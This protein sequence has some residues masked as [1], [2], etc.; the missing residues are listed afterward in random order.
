MLCDDC[1]K[2]PAC[3]HIT[4]VNNNQK[5]EKHLCEYCAQKT[6]EFTFTS[7]SGLSVQ[8][9]LKGMFNQG[10]AEAPQKTVVCPNCGMSYGDFSHNG[11]IGCSVCYST[12]ADRLERMLRR[13]HGANVHTGKVPARTGGA[14]VARQ[15]LK[16]MKRRLEM[17]IARE[18]YENAAKLRDEIREMERQLEPQQ[19]EGE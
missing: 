9:L 2:R 5:T 13:I 17:Y 10:Y 6:G 4:K 15:N 1:Q 3:V 12:F 7:E 19:G 8:D 16:K 11:K 14:L 18:E